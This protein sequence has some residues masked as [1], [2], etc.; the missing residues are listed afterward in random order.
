VESVELSTEQ[1]LGLLATFGVA[2]ADVGQDRDPQA[3]VRLR[4]ARA[5]LGAAE[6]HALYAEQGAI[7]AGLSREQITATAAAVFAGADATEGADPLVLLQARAMSLHA[8]IEQME[9]DPRAPAG[10]PILAVAGTV[11][12]ALYTLI[13]TRY[14]LAVGENPTEAVEKLAAVGQVLEQTTGRINELFGLAG[15]A[16]R[17]GRGGPGDK[18]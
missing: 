1:M 17:A 11:A 6:A 15:M 8:G 2:G 3:L 12:A 4:L 13:G 14:Q 18:N 7:E 9:P 5:V 10:D 16:G